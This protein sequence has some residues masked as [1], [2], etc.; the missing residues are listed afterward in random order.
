MKKIASFLALLLMSFS[1][2]AEYYWVGG[3]GNWTDISHW[4]TTSGGSLTP[5]VIPGPIDNVYFDV[6]SGFTT[7]SK[8]VT[9]D[10]TANVHN[11]TFKGSLVVPTFKENTSQILNIHGSSEWQTG[12]GIIDIKTIN[13]IDTK[14][15][16][17]I[18]SNGVQTGS[19]NAT[20]NFNETNKIDL[21]D[22]F[23]VYFLYHNAGVWNTNG[24]NVTITYSFSVGQG[25][26]PRTINLG[27]SHI[28]MKLNYGSFNTNS[29]NVTINAG[30]SNIHFPNFNRDYNYSTAYGLITY[31][32]QTFYDVSFEGTGG[33]INS[34]GGNT[35]FNKVTFLGD[36]RITGTTTIKNLVFSPSKTYVLDAGK[37]QT[38]LE[39]FTANTPVCG[40]WTTI[41]S[42]STGS[43]ATINASS[44]TL[45]NVSGAI[46]KD[47]NASGTA[48]FTAVN[49][50]D[51]GNNS[52]WIFPASTSLDLFWVGGSG[53]WNDK[54]HWSKTSGDAGGYC[55]PGPN[56]NTFFDAGSG[57]T[58][59][60]K[61]VTIDNT[62]YTK[63]ITFS[64]SPVAPILNENGNQEFNI[65]GSSE[66]QTGMGIITIRNLYYR[67]T[68]LPKKIKSN[69]VKTG[70][71]KLILEEELSIDLLDNFSTTYIDHKAGSFNTNNNNV[72]ITYGYDA[73]IGSKKRA[74]NLG[75][76]HIYMTLINAK[77]NAASPYLTV[78]AGTSHIHFT[79]FLNGYN[80]GD[81]GLKGYDRQVYYDVSFEKTGGIINNSL[82]YS[83]TFNKVTF[84]G[85]GRIAGSN[86][87]KQ[88]IFSPTKTY[89]FQEG[90]TQTIY[91]LFSAHTAQCGGWSTIN[92][93]TAG[94][95]AYIVASSNTTIDLSGVVM[96]NIDAAGGANFIANNSIDNGNNMGWQFPA[97]IGQDLFW[98]GASGNW[99][100]R[101]HWSKTSGGS[102]GYCVPGPND[103]T[104]F[105]AGSAFLNN[106]KTVTVDNMSYTKDITF[107]G[108]TVAPTF[109]QNGNQTFNIYGSSEWQTGMPNVNIFN[110][111]YRHTGKNKTIKSNGVTFSANNNYNVF[112]EEETSITLLD[113]FSTYN[114]TLS[115]GSWNTGN[116]DVY[117]MNI[118]DASNDDKTKT[119]NLGSSNIYLSSI[120]AIFKTNSL[121]TIVNAGT[122]HIHFTKFTKDYN[123]NPY[124]FYA[125]NE[126]TYHDLS[127][128]NTGGYMYNNGN[129]T[130]NKVELKGDALIK[131][132]NTFK[133]LI[134]TAGKTYTFQDNSM[135]TIENWTLGGNPCNVT[136]VK[137]ET[138]A[139]KSNVKITGDN[140]SFNFG[141]LRDINALGKT[142]HFGEQSTIA[143]Q[144]NNNLTYDPYNPGAFEGLGP[145]WLKH[146]VIANDPSTYI[147]ST[148]KFYG[149]ANTT[150]KW[151][152]IDGTS[153]GN[154]TLI[155][156]DNYL[157]LRKTGFGTFKVDVQ[158]SDGCK[159]DD[160]IYISSYLKKILVNPNTRFKVK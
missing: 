38:I 43:K 109:T 8:T 12:M 64:G 127:F 119:L 131:G 129:A 104:F 72:T 28:Y 134:F 24:H 81:Y 7:A 27:S 39:S 148:S 62:S 142:L 106:N 66:W 107:S 149:N 147:I 103:N 92:S 17:T 37:T 67:N 98:V 160:D 135:Q 33:V 71:D 93:T 65:Y 120:S 87:F 60:N 74:L 113:N 47:M 5:S 51:N 155:S 45:I 140:T 42:S 2:A 114:L 112:L 3:S 118:F 56:D 6:N 138:N 116:H 115:A 136:F 82:N 150:Y 159:S 121:L 158:Y 125:N 94:K 99:N 69:G 123:N 54:A 68:G 86:K 46:M 90:A 76:S 23:Q 29:A 110:I 139:I 128:E 151:Y 52:G 41:T 145:D 83:V 63:D 25:T 84:L 31:V 144:N 14:E 59:T 91:D 89:Q 57:F 126:Q 111:Y 48:N 70:F 11:I 32:N 19:N 96:Q 79:E 13:Y 105:D 58:S 10:N 16:K 117:I 55:V 122:S 133:D 156:T 26:L 36:G 53:N 20:V 95:K 30:T 18:K 80:S 61:T 75:S 153:T 102:G 101:L 88:L 4:R 78:N 35:T 100:D 124:G 21:L 157:D 85:D 141:N 22:D 44:A 154:Q 9:L 15:A 77:F 130:F 73:T 108:S 34:N 152:K 40:G 50:I 143:N 146:R 137:S 1:W 132:N 97:S 49:S